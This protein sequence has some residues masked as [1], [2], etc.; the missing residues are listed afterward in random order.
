V[1]GELSPEEQAVAEQIVRGGIPAVR[2]ALDEQNAALRSEGRPEVKTDALMSLA[3]TLLPR[4]R[5]AEWIDRAEA[6]VAAA[7]ELNL[8]D[9]RSVVV[10]ADDPA[11]AREESTRDLAGRLRAALER[12]T[13][14]AI[15]E[16]LADIAWSLDAGR[17]VRA[18][19]VSARP[20]QP[21]TRLP[22]EL[23]ARL[24]AAAS[25]ALAADV[26]ADRW[27]TVLDAVAYSPVRRLVQPAGAP[28]EPSDDLKATAAKH[29]SRVPAAAALFGIEAPAEP[30]A[31]SRATRATRATR[32]APP[33][34]P[35]TPPRPRPS[36]LPPPRPPGMPPPPPGAPIPPPPGRGAIPPP[37]PRRPRPIPPPPPAAGQ[38][39]PPPPAEATVPSTEEPPAAPAPPPSEQPPP[40]AAPAPPAVEGAPSRAGTPEAQADAAEVN[41]EE[42]QPPVSAP[43]LPDAPEPPDASHESDEPDDVADAEEQAG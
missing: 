8:R 13:E 37:P 31:R 26:P 19:R 29:A 32:P 16:W 28:T 10:S 2:Q 39:V 5:V 25:E 22:E 21:G 24:S 40:A 11:V 42:G 17:V 1:I 41:V 35:G 36:T 38:P 9:L 12:R 33:L 6:A 4:V 18:L 15:E 43:E 30:R 23:A 34:A 7:D 14:Q 20:P 3:E 27:A